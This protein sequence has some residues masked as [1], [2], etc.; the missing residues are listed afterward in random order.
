MNIIRT[1]ALVGLLGLAAP[2]ALAVQTED[3]PI[4]AVA[5]DQA[6]PD[7]AYAALMEEYETALYAWYDQ[8]DAVQERNEAGAK[9]AYPESPDAAFYPRFWALAERGQ[10][11]ARLWCLG[12]FGFSEVPEERRMVTK[13]RLYLDLI[14]NSHKTHGEALLQ[15][16]S[17][18]T[19]AWGDSLGRELAFALLDELAVVSGNPDLA[20]QVLYEKGSA[21]EWSGEEFAFDLAVEQYELLAERFP[22]HQLAARA[23]GK[24]FAAE[25]L[26]IGMQVPDI[27]G[28]DVDGKP[29]KLSDYEGKVAV[30]DFWGFW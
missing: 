30:I 1:A 28:V 13:L 18:E 19:D 6:Q 24:I 7:A 17:G 25:N 9:E 2:A 27:V 3:P 4:E 5:P 20:A 21:L 16:I 22:E 10:I 12:N 15:T 23:A 26:Q 29:L 8:L 14:D 11:D